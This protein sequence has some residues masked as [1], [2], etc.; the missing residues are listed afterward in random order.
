MAKLDPLQI[1][2]STLVN[3]QSS[4]GLSSRASDVSSSFEATLSQ[5]AKPAPRSTS[6]A[7]NERRSPARLEASRPEAPKPQ[8]K[9][10]ARDTPPSRSN[11]ETT[12]ESVE[13]S[14]PNEAQR[15]ERSKL[16]RASK[17]NR[18][19]KSAAQD[20]SNSADDVKSKDDPSS[21]DDKSSTK[22]ASSNEPATKDAIA[23]ADVAV[24]GDT[25]AT[26]DGL[27][28][29]SQAVNATPPLT[30]SIVV[31]AQALNSG[32]ITSQD[33]DGTGQLAPTAD[34]TNVSALGGVSD[35]A[36]T[37][38]APT[39]TSTVQ[40]AAAA[41]TTTAQSAEG[42][43]Q[44]AGET[45]TNK[46]T[47]AQSAIA[48]AQPI[49]TTEAAAKPDPN[50]PPQSL[51]ATL[52]TTNAA[53]N[54]APSEAKSEATNAFLAAAAPLLAGDT[55]AT[56]P[57]S[58]PFAIPGQIQQSSQPITPATASTLG[59]NDPNVLVRDNVPLSRLGV[60]IATTARA[61]IKEIEVRLDP[62]E[63]GKIDVRLDIDDSGQVTTH[64]IVER[65]STLDQLRRDAPNLERVLNQSGLKTDSGSL[66]FSL[67]DQNQ[68]SHQQNGDG[69]RQRRGIL[70]VDGL[71]GTSNP[72]TA[73]Q[74][75]YSARLR[76]G[77][78]VRL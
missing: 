30:A 12:K 38:S 15:N 48:S 53:P 54:R 31:A 20:R 19:D 45:G 69:R 51:N 66:Q 3:R 73:A 34:T 37:S 42:K 25:T 74:L 22:D 67:R 70:A 75:A 26:S 27:S 18:T 32:P 49:I 43:D 1:N 64:L 46:P 58:A 56:P 35:P 5:S 14:S 24:A 41:L 71:E 52:D 39:T 72:S 78:D 77:V 13:Q 47:A 33:N 60:E 36:V 21:V 17:D 23:P 62:P 16:G 61:G 55:S 9:S 7:T 2:L 8:V 29:L 6:N 28:A 11:D 59:A 50:Q 4:R 44:R 65:A 40:S 76:S 63:L 57:G 68:P 10:N